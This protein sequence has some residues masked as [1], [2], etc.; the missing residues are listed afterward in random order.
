M[1]IYS[2]FITH[3]LPRT[4]SL[5]DDFKIDSSGAT[6]GHLSLH[7]RT[8]ATHGR[9]RT[10]RVRDIR[11]PEQSVLFRFVSKLETLYADGCLF[12]GLAVR[13]ERG[14]DRHPL[15][16][17]SQHDGLLLRREFVLDGAGERARGV[18]QWMHGL[19]EGDGQAERGP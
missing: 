16:A 2:G 7:S 6:R 8:P 9:A 19:G 13:F 12:S 11:T 4:K 5:A 10:S 18:Q 3:R 17:S 1:L 15:A 14:E